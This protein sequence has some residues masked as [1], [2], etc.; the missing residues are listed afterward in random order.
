MR[1][2][3]TI[4]TT[5]LVFQS[6]RAQQ[7]GRG[8]AGARGQGGGRGQQAA[9]P[10]APANPGFE[11]FQNVETPEFPQSALLARIDGTVY[12][13]VQVTPQGAADKIETQ[14]ASAWADGPKLLVP[15]V[16]KAVRASKFKPEC[17]GKT[18]AVV[19]RYNL[20]GEAIAKPDVTVKTESNI[21]FIDSQP[22][23]KAAVKSG[24][25]AK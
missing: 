18:V 3:L 11:C 16:E 8:Q 1:I 14:V 5:L 19:F 17:A 6:G 23:L 24:A 12:A 7:G 21:M 2:V 25:P 9:A 15:P 13:S 4:A 22:E 20:H 10:P